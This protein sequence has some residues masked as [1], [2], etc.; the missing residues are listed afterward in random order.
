MRDD[1]PFDAWL[2]LKGTQA[3]T[4]VARS[5]P[6][7]RDMLKCAWTAARSVFGK[8]AK[9]EHAVMLLPH[10]LAAA[11]TERQRLLAEIE[12]RTKA[13]AKPPRKSPPAPRKDR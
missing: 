1:D 4:S 7:V 12:A 3:K 5:A 13:E 10:F 8:A 11:T 6:E 2:E 9:P